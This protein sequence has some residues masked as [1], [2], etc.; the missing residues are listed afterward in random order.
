MVL[1]AILD[2]WSI[3]TL[4][5]F[6]CLSIQHG[7]IRGGRIDKLL[8]CASPRRNMIEQELLCVANPFRLQQPIK[9]FIVKQPKG[10]SS[11]TKVRKSCVEKQ[12]DIFA[13]QECLSEET[14]AITGIPRSRKGRK[15]D[16]VRNKWWF[17]DKIKN[18]KDTAK[19][20]K[21]LR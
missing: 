19:K 13:T 14:E 3:S 9:S 1:I 10:V 12:G 2:A 7:D 15:L 11:G 16:E 20:T 18:M 21:L 17:Q 6:V 4:F 8:S 5:Q